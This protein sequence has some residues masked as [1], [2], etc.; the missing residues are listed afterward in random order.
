MAVDTG[1]AGSHPAGCRTPCSPLVP[2]WPRPQDVAPSRH[3]AR[4]TTALGVAG[5][6]PP[7]RDE[8]VSSQMACGDLLEVPEH[9]PA[10]DRSEAGPGCC[11][12][13]ELTRWQPVSATHVVLI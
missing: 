13:R 4:F 7:T 10:P 11:V 5:P 6:A 3:P 12:H 2:A 9:S 8:Q 1:R